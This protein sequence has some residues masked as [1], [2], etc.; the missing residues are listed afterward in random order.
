MAKAIDIVGE[1][2]YISPKD[3]DEEKTTWILRSLTG[4]EFMEC[5]TDYDTMYTKFVKR[6]LIGW[7]NFKDSKGEEIPFSVENMG[8][9]MPI[10]LQDISFKIQDI[11]V[12][13]EEETKNS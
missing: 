5:T 7:K 11:S 13:S 9:I 2:E 8:R 1:V 6:G 4:F 3:T 12:L 10:I